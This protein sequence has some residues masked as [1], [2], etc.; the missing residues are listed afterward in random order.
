M[1]DVLAGR[2]DGGIRRDIGYGLRAGA[3]FH[4]MGERRIGAWDVVE[5]AKGLSDRVVERGSLQS[6]GQKTTLRKK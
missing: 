6:L 5:L 2:G 4:L 1:A 3:F